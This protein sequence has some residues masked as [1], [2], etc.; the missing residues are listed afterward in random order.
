[1]AA[2]TFYPAVSGD[3]S[4]WTSSS[5][6]PTSGALYLG[7][8][9][10]GSYNSFVRFSN[11][12]IPAGATITGAY[13]KFTASWGRSATV[14]NL[15]VYFNNV[16]NAVAPTSISEANGLALTSAV[17]WNALSAWVDGT[18]YDTPSLITI[19]QAVID[20]AGWSSGNA[21]QIV[22]K[23]NA[24]DSSAY[25]EASS[26]DAV[27]G[28]EKAELH[29][30]WTG[31]PSTRI[32][33]LHS[34]ISTRNESIYDL[35]TEL[36]T[37]KEIVIDLKSRIAANFL[38][39]FANLST[40]I[41]AR[42]QKIVDL[43]TEMRAGNRILS[44]LYTDIRT[45]A[46]TIYDL[47]FE[48]NV[49]TY[50]LRDLKTAIETL[51]SK[52]WLNTE[53]KAGCAARWNFNTEWNPNRL[54]YTQIAAKKPYEFSFKTRSAEGFAATEPS[55]EFKIPGYSFPIRTLFLDYIA[56][57]GI[58]EYQLELWW[59]RGLIGKDGLKNVKIKAE[60][61]DTQYPGGYEVVTCNWLSC[62]LNDGEYKTINETPL[63]LGDIQCDSYLKFSLKVE[64]R[65]CSL[66]RGIVFFKLNISGDY[67][68]S[69]YGDKVVYQDGSRYHAGEQD[70]YQSI[71]FISRLYVVE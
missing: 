65:D 58:N 61:I 63:F 66:T 49:T 36:D 46:Q 54:L 55:V 14:V 47:K 27:S 18:Q 70:D 8:T 31:G 19:L 24:S 68:E 13:I 48:I 3:D 12:T 71:D 33:D 50:T 53:I 69:I 30:T 60:Y 1:M 37:N 42:D 52:W 6:N 32:T 38:T 64:C 21:L 43:L 51:R 17:A 23:D 5:F 57:G 62:A 9:A 15:N 67:K 7:A 29:V 11:V 56:V 44:D 22:I 39:N 10:A 34:S 45:R 28:A 4:F 25:R 35:K 26:Y 20:R 16:D 2:G 40:E 59:A 41:F